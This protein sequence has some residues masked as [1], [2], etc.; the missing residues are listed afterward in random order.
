M[1]SEDD[2]VVVEDILNPI[3]SYQK[4]RSIKDKITIVQEPTEPKEFDLSELQTSFKETITNIQESTSNTWKDLEQN[5]QKTLDK[6]GKESQ[7]LLDEKIKPNLD[8][9]VI[10]EKIKPSLD[11]TVVV[12]KS[13]PENTRKSVIQLRDTTMECTEK[14]MACTKEYTEKTMACTKESMLKLKDSTTE[15]TEKAV[16]AVKDISAEQYEHVKANC[17]KVQEFHDAHSKYYM[18][19]AEGVFEHID[20]SCPYFQMLQTCLLSIGMVLN[21]E[22]PVTGFIILLSLFCTSPSIALS[23]LCAL[24]SAITFQRYISLQNELSW[25]I[26]AGANIFLVGTMS[27]S[28]VLYSTFFANFI[29]QYIFAMFLGPNC[30]LIHTQLFSSSK[31]PLLWSYN[32]TMSVI[33]LAF[34]LWDNTYLTTIAS[35]SS[36]SLTGSSLSSISAIYGVSNPYTGLFILFGVFL[37][38]RILC[39]YLIVT[40]FMAS[41]LGYMFGIPLLDV[42]SGIVGYQAGLTALG[43]GYYFLPSKSLPIITAMAV[44]W[45]CILES[46]IGSIFYAL[47]GQPITLAIGYCLVMMPLS[48][49][50]KFGLERVEYENLSFPEEYLIIEEDENNLPVEVVKDVEEALIDA[51]EASRESDVEESEEKDEVEASK[52]PDVEED[53]EKD[54]EAS[55]EPDVEE[56]EEKGVVEQFRE[57]VKGESVDRYMATEATEETPLIPSSNV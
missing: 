1:G 37:C 39:A 29:G 47:L 53:E 27:S 49:Y 23:G 30:L 11:N 15:Y 32:I 54:V 4:G 5:T 36:F 26:R 12:V 22:N 20:L 51:V 10:Y 14:T 17:G 40:C 7:K 55:K 21:C 56:S 38:S 16:L 13:I 52:E 50:T 33:I 28:L 43:C 8:S 46:A 41:L 57:V 31:I 48:M 24:V 34:S 35:E 42:N 6:I 25:N 44:I 45:A 18:G 3:D 19:K 2:F 9:K